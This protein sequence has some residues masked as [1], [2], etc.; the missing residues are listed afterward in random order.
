VQTTGLEPVQ[1]PFWQVSVWVQALP[2]L[3]AVP[4][5]WFVHAVVLTAG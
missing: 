5:A 2:S 4:F 3:H 1:V